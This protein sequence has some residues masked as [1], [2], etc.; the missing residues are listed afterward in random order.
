[1]AMGKNVTQTSPSSAVL[2]EKQI[3]SWHNSVNDSEWKIIHYIF[4][5]NCTDPHKIADVK[6]NTIVYLITQV[7]WDNAKSHW[8]PEW[9]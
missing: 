3:K 1:M 7:L 9:F 8:F 6:L 4:L 2:M 5:D